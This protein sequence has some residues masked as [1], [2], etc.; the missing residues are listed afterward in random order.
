MK[1]KDPKAQALLKLADSSE[2]RIEQKLLFEDSWSKAVGLLDLASQRMLKTYG[3]QKVHGR[4]YPFIPYSS[5]LI[6]LAAMIKAV[7]ESITPEDSWKKVDAWYWYSVFSQRYTSAV[8]SKS[9]YDWQRIC[10]WIADD[11]EKPKLPPFS[12]G[13]LKGAMNEASPTAALAK[14]FYCWLMIRQVLDLKTGQLLQ[15]Y[16]E[17]V[18]DHIFPRAQYG[19]KAKSI[20]N[21]TLLDRS[22]NSEKGNMEPSDFIKDISL[23]S[24]HHDGDRI[25]RTFSSH[26]I[27]DKAY[28]CLTVNDIDGFLTARANCFIKFLFD[29]QLKY[30][31]TEVEGD[32]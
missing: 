13:Q 9:F 3:A 11:E 8:E 25:Y 2:N 30:I 10:Q 31:V 27:D 12:E 22:T 32:E 29:K 19:A 24:H 23:P 15:H 5:L 16:S 26:Y 6:P 21:F 17:C 4:K 7:E 20:F 1:N 18:V 14:A 28:D